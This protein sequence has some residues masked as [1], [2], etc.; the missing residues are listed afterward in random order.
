MQ[1]HKTTSRELV[2]TLVDVWVER[3][4][5]IAAFV[6]EVREAAVRQ[7]GKGE[8]GLAAKEAVERALCRG[9]HGM[10]QPGEWAREG[11]LGS[12]AI[13]AKGSGRGGSNLAKGVG[14]SIVDGARLLARKSI[15]SLIPAAI[16][17]VRGC[18]NELE[19]DNDGARCLLRLCGWVVGIKNA[20]ETETAIIDALHVQ[21]R[22][23]WSIE[24][25]TSRCEALIGG[26]PVCIAMLQL[27]EAL[28][29]RRVS[30][31]P[32]M[33]HLLDVLVRI[34]SFRASAKVRMCAS[35]TLAWCSRCPKAKSFLFDGRYDERTLKPVNNAI[36]DYARHLNIT[37][38]VIPQ[39]APEYTEETGI[40]LGDGTSRDVG[41][42]PMA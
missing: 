31:L 9:L 22:S 30:N 12:A 27:M 5:G 25:T 29:R 32:R 15:G 3:S 35:A 40:C 11:E 7:G 38:W 8:G 2:S 23:E 42:P 34:Y 36:K 10:C 33:N 37:E 28:A 24:H 13:G 21:I 1:T 39:D 20:T 4:P 26:E 17:M 41:L 19:A 18:K 14:G 6:A 16:P